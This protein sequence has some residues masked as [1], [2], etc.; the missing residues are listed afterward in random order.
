MQDSLSQG[1]NE[2]GGETTADAASNSVLTEI[3][4]PATAGAKGAG[5]TAAVVVMILFVRIMA[6]AGWNWETAA[7]IAESFDFDDAVPI[8]FGTLF[9]MPML[10]GITASVVLP[11]AVYRLVLIRRSRDRYWELADW[12]IIVLLALILFVLFNSYG[13]WWPIVV[14]G[15]MAVLLTAT[16]HFIHGGEVHTL[17]V[18]ASRRVGT[19]L[20]A[21]LVVLSVFVTTPWDV[22]E[23]I[24]TT[25]GVIYGHVLESTPGFLKVLTDD[26]ETRILLTGEVL[27]RT[28]EPIPR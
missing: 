5:L 10:T 12:L 18:E 23:R 16:L 25:S 14:T 28:A 4:I 22:R 13:I 9:E 7:D 3:Q 15:V 11:L 19:L 20:I 21:V 24:E 26:R 2:Q 1:G 8:I 17:L 27:A 6:V